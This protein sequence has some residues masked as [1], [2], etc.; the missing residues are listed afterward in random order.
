[1]KIASIADHVDLMDTVAQW[2]GD[3][4]GAEWAAQVR[5]STCRDKIPTIFVALEDNDLLGTAMLV[6][7]DMT[8]RPD[9]TPWLGG[10][11][12]KPSRRREGIAGALVRHAMNEARRMNI[13]R[14]WL[15]TASSRTLYER[16]GWRF[17]MLADYE[18]EQVTIMR[19][20]LD[21]D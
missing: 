12:V 8:T 16:L 5:E 4:W 1:M 6:A 18:G 15:Y 20:D 11:Y 19:R 13:R 3:E 10:V 14:L 17:E 21:E 2:H 7:T 9:L